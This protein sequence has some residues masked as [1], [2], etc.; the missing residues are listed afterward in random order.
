MLQFDILTIFPKMF[1]PVLGES[2]VKRAQEKKK[3]QIRIHNLRDFSTDKHRKVDDRPFGGGPGMLMA[4]Q[5]IFD[6]ISKIKGKS[7]VKVIL[8][9][10]AGKP[11]TQKSAKNLAK[12]KQLIIICGHYEGVDERVREAL[13][14]EDISVGDYVLTGG[15]LPPLALVDC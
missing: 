13:V 15:G 12:Q 3:I 9:S 2:M 8:M 6:C 10:P 11:L 5:P 1:S 14:D 7:S 4:P